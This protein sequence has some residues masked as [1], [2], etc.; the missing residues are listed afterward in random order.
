MRDEPVDRAASPEEA[1]ALVPAGLPEEP[2][3]PAELIEHLG[4]RV[5]TR[6]AYPTH[7]R[8]FSFIPGPSSF[9]GA[10][11]NL[12]ANGFNVYAG[13]WMEGATGVHIELEVLDWIR[14]ALGFPE[15]GGGVLL[16]GGSTANL[17]A[18]A[19]ARQRAGNPEAPRIYCT[20]DT[21]VSVTRSLH[22]LGLPAEAGVSVPVDE[23]RRMDVGALRARMVADR[24]AGR[25]L[26]AVVATA[27]TT[28]TGAVD[29]L[30]ELADVAGEFGVWLHVDGAHGAAAVF[31][32]KLRPSLE[33]IERADS[34]TLDPHKWLFQPYGAGALMVRDREALPAVFSTRAAYLDECGNDPERVNF[35]DLGPELSRP[36]RGVGLWLLGHTL[37]RKGLA[38]AVEHGAGL[39]EFAAHRI[40]ASPEWELVTE[41]SL[42]IVCFRAL[43]RELPPEALDR[44]QLEAAARLRE[45]GY[46]FVTTTKVAGRRTL[47]L[48]ILHPATRPADI[49][50]TLARLARHAEDV[51]E[52]IDYAAPG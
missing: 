27:G 37:G 44:V 6:L 46:A 9:L 38:E 19:V 28:S 24:D 32:P 10:L 7:P 51:A 30:G 13:T 11:G 18:V 2:G 15:A 41:P 26:V 39:A 48:A 17:C 36:L 1:R 31:S 50:G 3:D 20:E 8:F 23:T 34:V 52:E 4:S 49:D 33:G 25:D 45:E 43:P 21:H 29:P 35:F 5:L 16:S 40:R 14:E 22:I 47:R 42:G 12:L